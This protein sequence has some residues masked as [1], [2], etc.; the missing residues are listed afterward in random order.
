MIRALLTKIGEKKAYQY[1]FNMAVYI[2]CIWATFY[3]LRNSAHE[4]AWYVIQEI[5]EFNGDAPFQQRL[6]FVWI[7]QLFKLILPSL[8]YQYA[9]YLSQLVAIGLMYYTIKRLAGL[10][11]E[12]KFAFI[13]QLVCMAMITPTFWYYT[14]YDIGMIFF[15]ALGLYL[16]ITDR[17]LWFIPVFLMGVI[18]HEMMLFTAMFYF[19]IKLPENKKNPRFWGNLIIL[20]VIFVLERII[21]FNLVPGEYIVESGKIW[22]NLYYLLVLK[23]GFSDH[24]MILIPW[25]LAA[26]YKFGSAPIE[27]RRCLYIFPVFLMI[28]LGVGIITELRLFNV[29]VPVIVSL[30]IYR[31]QAMILGKSDRSSITRDDAGDLHT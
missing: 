5:M 2:G 21:V 12:K 24:F 30:I 20:V 6:V 22:T 23:S 3:A 14:F 19:A 1:I 9:F 31:F 15:I 18:N 16:I 8:S 10:Y 11:I 28:M 25:Y 17:F 4:G 7:A 29:F 26:L 13:S 27:L